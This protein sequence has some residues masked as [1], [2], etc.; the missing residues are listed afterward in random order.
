MTTVTGL[1]PSRMRAPMPREKHNS[2][3]ISDLKKIV[4]SGHVLTSP[5]GTQRFRKGFRFGDGLA[6]A[7]VRPGNL[8]EQWRV[9]NTCVAAGKIVIMQAANTGLTG[10]STPDGDQYDR[11][12]VNISTLRIDQIHLID[13]GRQVICLPGATLFELEKA[14]R[15]FCQHSRQQT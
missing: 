1:T 3:L 13:E 9:L 8:V 12:I 11:E 6:L 7:V 14:L 4:G 15:R 5:S 2:Q 10:G